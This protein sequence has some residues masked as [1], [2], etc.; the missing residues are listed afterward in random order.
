MKSIIKYLS[1][2]ISL[3]EYLSMKN[4]LNAEYDCLF[5]FK[6]NFLKLRCLFISSKDRRSASNIKF[7]SA[8]NKYNLI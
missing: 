2:S 6:F 1:S 5:L 7:L 4:T 8:P 3:Y